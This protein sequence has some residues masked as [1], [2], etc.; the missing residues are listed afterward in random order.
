MNTK[1]N[2]SLALNVVLLI[3]IVILYVLHFKGAPTKSSHHKKTADTSTVNLSQ[4]SIVFVNSDSLFKKYDLFTE[5]RDQMEAKQKKM[6]GELEVKTR[7]CFS[8]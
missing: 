3:A 6:E 4:G 2:L 8:R 1:Q 7:S 5:M